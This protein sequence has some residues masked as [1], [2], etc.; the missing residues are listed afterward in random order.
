MVARP[1]RPRFPLVDALP[2]FVV[3]LEKPA[4]TLLRLPR[5]FID[6]LPASG[7]AGL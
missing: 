3:W 2:E 6:E 1:A 4:S 5:F 7:L